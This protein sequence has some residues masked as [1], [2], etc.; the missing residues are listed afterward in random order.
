VTS[1]WN[2]HLEREERRYR[3]G[4][5]RLPDAEDADARQRQLTRMGN[6]AGGAGLA[7]L[8]LGR[9][10]DAA[11]WFARA[12]ER[13]RESYADAPPGSWGRPVG[14]IKN[15][16]LAGDWESAEAE[17]RFALDAGAAEAESPIGRYAAALALLVLGR[18][19]EA[20]AHADAI[21]VREDFPAPVGDA[22]ATV[23]AEDPLGYVEA[24]EAVLE[25]F[26]TRDEY[27]ED[28]PVADTVIVLQALA[29]R[30][31]MAAELRSPLLPPAC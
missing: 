19:E 27:L 24:V 25:S 4:E 29:G 26:E 11:G 21:R 1:D 8:M 23:A 5:A 30:R 20:R 14:M 2:A 6:A 22:L 31:G 17:A 10:D 15:R 7:L 12:A 9:G 18:D 3:D 13:Y 28:I 16:L